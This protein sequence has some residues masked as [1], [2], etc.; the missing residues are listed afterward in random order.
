VYYT[1]PMANQS[2]DLFDA[3]NLRSYINPTSE[4][5]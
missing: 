1:T 2:E 5:G 3:R 4:V